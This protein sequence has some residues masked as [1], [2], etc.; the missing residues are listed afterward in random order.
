MTLSTNCMSYSLFA[1]EEN[2][3]ILSKT[4][5][6]SMVLRSHNPVKKTGLIKRISRFLPINHNNYSDL[7]SPHNAGVIKVNINVCP[8]LIFQ[9]CIT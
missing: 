9:H 7:F 1:N 4:K 6:T 2:D 5:K 3:T 8:N